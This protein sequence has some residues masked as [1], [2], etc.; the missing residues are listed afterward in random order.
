MATLTFTRRQL[1]DR[2]WTTPIASLARELGLSGRGLG[3]LCARY[4]IPVPPRGYW[5][6]RAFG[7][8]V[9]K[10][11]LPTPDTHAQKI[12][13][14]APGEATVAEVSQTATHPLIAAEGLPANQISV[15]EDLPLSDPLVVATQKRL[16]RTKREPSG[17]IALPARAL[18]VHTS[19]ALHER[20]F[21]IMQALL[22]AFADRGF[23]VSATAEGTYVRT[24]GDT[25]VYRCPRHGSML[26]PPH[27]RVTA[28]PH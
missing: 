21:R 10:P 6:K 2:A 16:L 9:A 1:Y 17:L 28:Q 25:H 5:A 7:K 14:N 8:R 12:S 24:D 13:F 23:P 15:P 26:L 18:A 27:G 11:P 19:R 3:K 4:N 20:A 22:T